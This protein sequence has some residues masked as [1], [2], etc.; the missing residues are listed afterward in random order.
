MPVSDPD[1][2]VERAGLQHHISTTRG[3][4]ERA[5]VQANVEARSCLGLCGSGRRGIYGIEGR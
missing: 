3:K 5:T 1:P 4:M 2:V